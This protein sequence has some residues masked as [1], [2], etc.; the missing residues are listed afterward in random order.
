MSP[1]SPA[2]EECEM[3]A[4]SRRER[5]F[6]V[7]EL[8]VVIAIIGVLAALIYPVIAS[9]R[10]RAKQTQCISHLMQVHM[11]LKQFQL[12][13]HRYPDFIASPVDPD[14]PVPLE[15]SSGMVND[16]VVS[17]FPYY[18]DEVGI[19][20]CPL[21]ILNG[22]KRD[23]GTSPTSEDT[24]VDP[25]AALRPGPGGTAYRLYKYSSYDCQKPEFHDDGGDDTKAEIHYSTIW[26]REDNPDDAFLAAN[27]DYVRQLRWR[28]PPSDTVVTWCSFHRDTYGDGTPKESSKDLVLFLDGHVKQTP[29]GR[30]Y[31][32]TTAWKSAR[33]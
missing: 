2:M 13:E 7:I 21:S 30:V 9:S 3:I 29:T 20:R 25:L 14:D 27:P 28:G 31:D 5:G 16:R 18:I 32:W 24:L 11:Q 12:D 17:L 1:G 23:Y 10:T 19:L 26:Q 15:Q 33:P 6:T 22:D 4:I 8:L